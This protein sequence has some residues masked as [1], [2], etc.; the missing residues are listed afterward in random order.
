MPWLTLIIVSRAPIMSSRIRSHPLKTTL[1]KTV[2]LNAQPTV[3]PRPAWKMALSAVCGL[4]LWSSYNDAYGILSTLGCGDVAD[5]TNNGGTTAAETN[6]STA[7]S[8][9]SS[10]LCGGPQKL[11]LYLWN[12]VLNNWQTPANIGKYEV[13]TNFSSYI[14]AGILQLY[15]I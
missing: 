9:D 11:Q 8:G 2:L 3:I 1:L 5:I 13:R 7:C 6:C 10:H 12:G 4:L 14:C 15:S